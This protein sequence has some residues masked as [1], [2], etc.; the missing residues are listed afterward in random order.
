MGYPCR[1]ACRSR[2][3]RAKRREPRLLPTMPLLDGTG[4][5]AVPAGEASCEMRLPVGLAGRGWIPHPAGPVAVCDPAH[6]RHARHSLPV[7]RGWRSALESENGLRH[8][9]FTER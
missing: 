9:V 7:A 8:V 4:L 2:V 5:G 1:R 3:P 6:Q